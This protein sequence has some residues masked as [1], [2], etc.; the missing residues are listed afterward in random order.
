MCSTSRHVW[1]ASSRGNSSPLQGSVKVMQQSCLIHF[2]SVNAC[3]RESGQVMQNES[4]ARKRRAKT[5]S[6][7]GSIPEKESRNAEAT[8]TFRGQSFL[9]MPPDHMASTAPSKRV[10]KARRE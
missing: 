3:T 7:N 5:D 1:F 9:E 6:L 10:R 2:R 8:L 4:S